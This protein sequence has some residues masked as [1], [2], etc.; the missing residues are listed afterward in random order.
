[1]AKNTDLIRFRLEPEM[2]VAIERRAAEL[3]V[4]VSDYIRGVVATDLSNHGTPTDVEAYAMI[5]GKEIP[6]GVFSVAIRKSRK[7]RA[8]KKGGKK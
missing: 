2:R 4:S 6:V 1:M 3:D 7:K 5:D 8:V